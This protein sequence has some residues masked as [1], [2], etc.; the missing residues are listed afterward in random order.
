ME[1]NRRRRKFAKYLSI[2]LSGVLLFAFI[3]CSNVLYLSQAIAGH[4]RIMNSREPI[5]KLLETN[6]FDNET[7][8]KLKLALAVREY[9]SRELDLPRNKSYTVFSRVKGQY[10]GWNI[11]CA[12]KFSVEPIQ[13]CFPIAGCVVY[14]GY[15]SKNGALKFAGKMEKRGFDVFISRISAYSTLGWY[16][17]PLLSSHLRLDS[18]HLARLIIHELTHQKFYVPGDSRFNE[19]FA[20]AVERAGVLRWLKSIGRDDQVI[21]AIKMQDMEDIKIS[22]ILK[23][24]TQLSNIYHSKIDPN[25]MSHKKDSIFRNLKLDIDNGNRAVIN[26][27]KSNGE[28]FVLNNAYLVP[29]FTYHSLGPIFQSMLDSVDGNLPQFY[30]N[31]KKLGDLPFKQRQSKLDSLQIKFSTPASPSTYFVI[32]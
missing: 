24:R 12:P 10:V 17:D 22:K 14:R 21:Q 15:F 18:I 31:V 19:G 16:N 7:K 23:A 8:D 1:F 28:D 2:I 6:Q 4:L 9:A 32:Q 3:G 27:P 20:S 30:I 26:L 13:W 11:F 29:V 25:S 5:K